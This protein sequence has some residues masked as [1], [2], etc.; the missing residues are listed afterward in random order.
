MKSRYWKIS[1]VLF[2]FSAFCFAEEPYNFK[3][4]HFIASYCGCD[5]N[6]LENVEKLIQVM[7]HAVNQSGA[8]I[9]DSSSYQ[10]PGNG[11]TMVFLLSESHASIHTY[12]EHQACFV[13]LFTCGD[14]CSYEKFHQSLSSYLKPTC[15]HEKLLIRQEHSWEPSIG[16]FKIIGE[17]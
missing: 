4:K 11:L 16:S 7:E 14:H 1:I 3:G 6:A 8:S 12:P 5:S 2:L 13:D 10:F 9:L 15:V 17:S